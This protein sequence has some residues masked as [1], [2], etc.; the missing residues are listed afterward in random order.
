MVLFR[1]PH[2]GGQRCAGGG[3]LGGALTEHWCAGQVK[4][5]PW[6]KGLDWASLARTKA[7]FIPT[8]ENEYDTSYFVPK[9]VR[10]ATPSQRAR[11]ISPAYFCSSGL[12][13]DAPG[14]NVALQL[15]VEGQPGMRGG[16]GAPCLL[17]P[18]G[19]AALHSHGCGWRAP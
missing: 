14:S 5:H 18:A 10:P 17:P 9:A 13:H 16:S 19:F 15:K 2:G 1:A 12:D 4:L 7:A 11:S 6:F 3:A 8:V